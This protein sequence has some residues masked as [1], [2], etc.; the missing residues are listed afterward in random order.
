MIANY[1]LPLLAVVLL[2]AFWAV[3][4]VW[5][6]QHDPDVSSRSSKCGGCRHKGECE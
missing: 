4:Q 6:S 2:C 1:I 3:F 5:L